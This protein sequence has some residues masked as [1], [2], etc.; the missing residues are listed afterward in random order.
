MLIYT[1]NTN[2]INVDINWSYYSVAT[3]FVNTMVIVRTT[4]AIKMKKKL[5]ANFNMCTFL[6]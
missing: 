5:S 2:L 3:C 4:V 1:I 6:Y